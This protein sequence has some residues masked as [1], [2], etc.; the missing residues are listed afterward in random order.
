MFP[1]LNEQTI[2]T[3]N[4]FT[5]NELKFSLNPDLVKIKGSHKLNIDDQHESA[6]E[7][8][9]KM[10]F[11]LS[12][13]F[14]E[15]DIEP[16]LNKMLAQGLIVSEE[17]TELRN[18]IADLLNHPDLNQY[19]KEDCI[20]KNEAE[21]I[22]SD[23]ELL[24]PDKIITKDKTAIVIDYKTGKENKKYFR[25]MCKYENALKSMGYEDIKKILVYID[26]KRVET[27]A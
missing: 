11:I 17:I 7:K 24:R 23:S 10:H 1:K 4:S 26:E 15:K 27:L 16:V 2:F 20:S 19:Y 13:V 25:Q 18:T 9:I 3:H 8:G 12:Q 22:T 14:S 5:I 6:R 21:I